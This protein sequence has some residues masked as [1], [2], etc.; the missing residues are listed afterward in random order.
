MRNIIYAYVFSDIE[1]TAAMRYAHVYSPNNFITRKTY[2][3]WMLLL[4]SKW[5][6]IGP[7]QAYY[8]YELSHRY[9]HLFD[10]PHHLY[11]SCYWRALAL[12][13][14]CRQIRA[15][16]RLLPYKNASYTKVNSYAFCDWL[17]GLDLDTRLVV[18]AAAQ[19]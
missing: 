19:R 12:T 17:M 11:N 14:T 1:W 6:P 2:W 5:I 9:L 4:I 18:L 3:G 16:C 13:Q 8:R 10:Y 7:T 15:E